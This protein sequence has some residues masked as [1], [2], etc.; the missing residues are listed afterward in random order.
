MNSTAE[1]IYS[2][3]ILLLL[4]LVLQFGL[5]YAI[6]YRLTRRSI[7]VVLFR[8]VPISRTPYERIREV[9][10]PWWHAESLGDLFAVKFGNRVY[11]RG[12]SVLIRRKWALS[13][14][15]SP[16]DPEEFIRELR[17]RAHQRTGK[18]PLVS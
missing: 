11:A 17:E 3:L 13:I 5:R 14:V 8:V 18:W 9:S 16:D 1:L 10:G 7:L 12:G 2:I 15:L 6:T 4:A